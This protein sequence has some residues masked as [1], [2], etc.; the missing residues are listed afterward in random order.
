MPVAKRRTDFFVSEQGIDIKTQ[1]QLMVANDSYNTKSSY[2][3]N[4]DL[5]SDNMMPFIDKHMNYLGDHP[6][7]DPMQYMSNLRLITR[8]R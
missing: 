2:S 8:L 7:V 6:S 1:L 3:A 4:G 5:Y